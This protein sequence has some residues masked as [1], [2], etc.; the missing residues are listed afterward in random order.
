MDGYQQALDEAQTTYVPSLVLY[1]MAAGDGTSAGVP[2]PAQLL[3][4][5]PT[6]DGLFCL[7]DLSAAPALR[8][9]RASGLSI[10][11][12]IAIAG[13]DDARAAHQTH[14][15]RLHDGARNGEPSVS[16]MPS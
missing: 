10:P 16:S 8:T 3:A 9:L 2:E 6:V 1:S 13:F 14:R 12:A 5:D 7:T 15:A 11:R 4:D